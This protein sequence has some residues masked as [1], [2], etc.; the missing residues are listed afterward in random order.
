MSRFENTP[1][2][3]GSG[4]GAST[5]G[6]ITY[7]WCGVE[8]PEGDESIGHTSFGGKQI[9]DCC[10]ETIETAVLKRMEDIIPWYIRILNEKE[11]GIRQ[12]KAQIKGLKAALEKI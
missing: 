10:F 12:R 1:E 9:C 11:K 6:G 5:S 4:L 3:F 8:Y 2:L 7:D